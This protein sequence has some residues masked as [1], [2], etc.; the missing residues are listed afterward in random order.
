[1]T[2][3]HAPYGSQQPIISPPRPFNTISINYI[4]ALPKSTPDE[5]DCVLS[6]TD[7]FSKGVTFAPGQ[8][9]ADAE[10]WAQKLLNQLMIAEW[11]VPQAIL[12]ERDTRFVSDM[13]QSI[14]KRL[15]V[16]LLF[17][18][19]YHPQTDGQSERTSQTAEVALCYLITGLP[20]VEEWPT[21]L[22]RLQ[23]AL[24]NAK[25]AKNA[26]TG[27]SPN[28]IIYSFRTED[29]VHLL[30]SNNRLEKTNH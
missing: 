3:C 23:T 1:M 15:G 8:I 5:Y 14:F 9:A 2:P 28:E 17:S 26:T 13:W 19:A 27:L 24:N 7:K 20:N 6:V 30:H 11:G 4:L 22:P 10:Y 12:S 21:L 25:N 16:S 29:T 18:T